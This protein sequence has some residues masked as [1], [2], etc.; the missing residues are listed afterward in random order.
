MVTKTE[1][2]LYSS[3]QE[4]WGAMLSA[5]NKAEHTIDIEQYIF[6]TDETGQRFIA[7]LLAARQR[8]VKVRILCDSVGSEGMVFDDFDEQP[9]LDAG[10]EIVFFSPARFWNLWKIFR[11]SL[12]LLRDHSKILIIDGH[13]GFTG[14]VGIRADMVSWRDSHV[15][16]TGPVVSA[17]VEAFERMWQQVSRGR[18][19]IG[20]FSRFV[21]DSAFQFVMNFPKPHQR[22]IYYAFLAAIKSAQKYI[23]LTTPYFI[24]TRRFSRALKK[25]VARGVDVR[26]I[27]PRYNDHQIVDLAS[28]SYY[29][30]ALRAGIRIFRYAPSMIHGKIAVIDDCWASVG[31]ANLDNLS[32]L[33]N[34][35]G[36]L[37][38]TDATFVGETCA[39]FEELLGESPEVLLGEWKKRPFHQK[40][41]EALTWPFH[42]LL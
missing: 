3:S 40:F 17:M 21:P 18:R 1:W 4:A 38:S 2:Q 7:A 25:A 9:L 19:I 30:V 5:I 42:R 37:F 36:N 29:T 23:Y 22:Y 34:Y 24:P 10:I 13:T 12:W 35:E 41:L 11:F 16:I 14:G 33:L 27:V 20:G 6:T 8:G 15:C 32:F 28:R 39:Q 26:L 31:S